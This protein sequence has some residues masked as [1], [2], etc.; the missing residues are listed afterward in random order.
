MMKGMSYCLPHV[1]MAARYH[2]NDEKVRALGWKPEVG[3][4]E[5][6][7]R[8]ST[9]FSRLSEFEHCADFWF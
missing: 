6:I 8:T 9:P 3:F 7:Q 2:I 1:L 5:G 4:D